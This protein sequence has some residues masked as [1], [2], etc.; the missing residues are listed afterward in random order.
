MPQVNS[1]DYKCIECDNIDNFIKEKA[2]DNF[3]EKIKCSKCGKDSIRVWGVSKFDIA[4]GKC[5]NTKDG[6]KGGI[7]NHSS[8]L[9]KYKGTKVGGNK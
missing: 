6:W 7:Y 2:L 4:I 9:G 8:V 1:S 3:P 5:G